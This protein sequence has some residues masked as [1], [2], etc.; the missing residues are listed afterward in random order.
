MALNSL[1]QIAVGDSDYETAATL[2]N[3]ILDQPTRNIPEQIILVRLAQVYE[4]SG[5]L[6]E[7]L[8]TYRRITTDYTGTPSASEA[9]NRIRQLEP[10][11]N[12]EP[13]KEDIAADEP[14]SES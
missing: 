4:H 3:Q 12:P 5:K 13:E 10:R 11:V 9:Q 1:S 7:A 14:V 2:L 6:V 8:E